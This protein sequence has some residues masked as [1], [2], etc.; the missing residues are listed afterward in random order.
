MISSSSAIKAEVLTSKDDWQDEPR[1]LVILRQHGQTE[2][3]LA[4]ALLT[5]LSE[6]LCVV[7]ISRR[8]RCLFQ[9]K[10]SSACSK[11]QIQLP[12]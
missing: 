4:R 9:K 8:C 11:V 1:A 7:S 2:E 12:A 3:L 5:S 6:L 10:R